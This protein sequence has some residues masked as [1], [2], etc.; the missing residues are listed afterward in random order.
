M[1]LF[2]VHVFSSHETMQNRVLI[3]FGSF[4]YPDFFD[5]ALRNLSICLRSAEGT[6]R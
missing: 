5:P 6:S 4:A 1:A 2:V 3:Q